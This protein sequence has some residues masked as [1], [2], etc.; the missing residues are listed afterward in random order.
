VG[1]PL[2]FWYMLLDDLLVGK[3]ELNLLSFFYF[4]VVG[5]LKPMT[6]LPIPKS[7]RSESKVY[8]S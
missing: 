7:L 5:D 3:L 2:S 6:T 1:S 8:S 4:L